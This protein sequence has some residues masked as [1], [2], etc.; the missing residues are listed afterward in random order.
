MPTLKTWKDGG[1]GLLVDV[2]DDRIVLQRHSFAF[3][4]PIDV[5]WVVPL[6][7]GRE[8]PFAIDARRE[9]S[10]SP[11]F[12]PWDA[13]CL[14]EREGENREKKPTRQLV[15]SFPAAS[16]GERP[17][18]YEVTVAS[19]EPGVKAAS[20]CILAPDFYLPRSRR[21]GRAEC[22]FALAELPPSAHRRVSVRAFN[23]FRK[24]GAPI[25]G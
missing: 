13:I 23:S 7:P 18:G 9:V 3:N 19:D 24:Y 15:V 25:I 8:K 4:E 17:F 14:A 21:G 11:E 22:V 10:V 12:A 5:D 20:K 1:Q 6:P 16:R 2:F